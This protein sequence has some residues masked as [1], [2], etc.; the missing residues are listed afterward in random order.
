MFYIHR[1]G[2]L[3]TICIGE[4][5]SMAFNTTWHHSSDLLFP[6]FYRTEKLWLINLRKDNPCH[7]VIDCTFSQ[8]KV[9]LSLDYIFRF[10]DASHYFLISIFNILNT[11]YYET[12][13][14]HVN[15]LCIRKIK[16]HH[17]MNIAILCLMNFSYLIFIDPLHYWNYE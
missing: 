10:S 8:E 15:P 11:Y 2:E 17:Q 16:K 6:P 1:V 4:L 5:V 14:P 12:L 9:V 13:S 3:S 7:S